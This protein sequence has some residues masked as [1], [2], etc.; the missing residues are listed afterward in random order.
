MSAQE[1]QKLRAEGRCFRCRKTGHVASDT[2]FHPDYKPRILRPA[3][4][5]PTGAVRAMD[6]NRYAVLEEETLVDEYERE[7]VEEV[8][9]AQVLSAQFA[10]LWTPEDNTDNGSSQE[11]SPPSQGNEGPRGTGSFNAPTQSHR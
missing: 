7:E 10:H 8:A 1:L 9:T 4:P 3:P 6:G 11:V 5:K 2:N